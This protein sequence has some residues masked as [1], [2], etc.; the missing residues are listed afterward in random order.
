MPCYNNAASHGR[1]RAAIIAP[2]RAAHFPLKYAAENRGPTLS[3]CRA[4]GTQPLCSL[5]SLC[6]LSSAGLAKIARALLL[7]PTHHT[8]THTHTHTR[9]RHGLPPRC[10][11]TSSH[12][13]SLPHL[14]SLGRPQWSSAEVTSC[15]YITSHSPLLFCHRSLPPLR[16][17]LWHAHSPIAPRAAGR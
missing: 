3:L 8:H 11:L 1:L 12:G 4:R 6:A 16:A 7:H 2:S 14:S 15:L 13:D 10:A 5:S 17:L 9:R